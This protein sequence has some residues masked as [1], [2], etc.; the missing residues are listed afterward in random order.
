MGGVGRVI[1]PLKSLTGSVSV[2]HDLTG[3]D[4]KL[5]VKQT[6]LPIAV[7]LLCL[8]SAQVCLLNGFQFL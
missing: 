7:L 8:T 5:S 3:F 6:H 1:M 4:K 2:L